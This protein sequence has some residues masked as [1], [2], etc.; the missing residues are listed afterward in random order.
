MSRKTMKPQLNKSVK[1]K[2]KNKGDLCA[3]NSMSEEK[4][5]LDRKSN[6]PKT[7][8]LS[9]VCLFIRWKVQN[10]YFPTSP[11]ECLVVIKEFNHS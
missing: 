2:T 5:T 7:L 10:Q 6:V 9:R 3:Q 11:S 4:H 8:I 1:P